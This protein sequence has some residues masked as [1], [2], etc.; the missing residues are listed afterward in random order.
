M[1]VKMYWCG[2]DLGSSGGEKN[3]IKKNYA[4]CMFLGVEIPKAGLCLSLMPTCGSCWE[5][6]SL[7]LRNTT[8]CT[9]IHI[10]KCPLK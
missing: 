3:E 7:L 9:I 10:Y 2:L 6:G 5:G 4:G 8:G 1:P